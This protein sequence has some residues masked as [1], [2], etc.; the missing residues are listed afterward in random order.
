MTLSELAL[1]IEGSEVATRMPL[2]P[3]LLSKAALRAKFPEGGA[4]ETRPFRSRLATAERVPLGVDNLDGEQLRQAAKL[5]AAGDVQAGLSERRPGRTRTAR[6]AT[7]KV[8]VL[9]AGY[10]PSQHDPS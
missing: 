9:T 8:L 5:L 2:S 7:L 10:A 3:S 6:K 1:F 4:V